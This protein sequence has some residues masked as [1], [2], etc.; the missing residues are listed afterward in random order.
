MPRYSYC[1][2]TSN[3]ATPFP[4]HWSHPY[5]RCL[6]DLYPI[7]SFVII[8]QD[9]RINTLADDTPVSLP[10]HHL[11]PAKPLSWSDLHLAV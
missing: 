8:L 1:H 7:R 5:F 6:T 3:M 4:I 9:I 2:H 10:D 11:P